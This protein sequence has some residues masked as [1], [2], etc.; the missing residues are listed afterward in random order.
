MKKL[1][2]KK[3]KLDTALKRKLENLE[4]EPKTKTEDILKKLNS[5]SKT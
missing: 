2:P 5:S 1:K 3:S 4:V